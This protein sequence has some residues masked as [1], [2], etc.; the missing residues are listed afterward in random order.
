M[1]AFPNFD[2]EL[3][4]EN[5]NPIFWLKEVGQGGA[6]RVYTVHKYIIH[7]R[8]VTLCICVVNSTVGWKYRTKTEPLKCSSKSTK[9]KI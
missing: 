4:L 3:F 5:K 7:I 2:V 1:V 6:G 8:T 9:C